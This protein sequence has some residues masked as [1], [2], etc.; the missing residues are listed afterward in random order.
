[1]TRVAQVNTTAAVLGMV[2]SAAPAL[3][4]LPSGGDTDCATIAYDQGAVTIHQH[5][6]HCVIDWQTFDIGDGFTV[7]FDQALPTWRTLNRVTGSELSLIAG[8]MVAPGTVYFVNPAGII[9]T[10]TAEINVGGIYAVAGSMTD[11]DFMDR[12]DLFTDLAGNVINEGSIFGA[13]VHMIGRRVVNDGTI[14]VDGVVTLLAGRDEVLIREIGDRIMVRIDGTDL[15]AELAVSTGNAIPTLTGPA[16]IENRGTIHAAGGRIVL[17]AGDLT[18]LAIRN[19]GKIDAGGGGSAQLAAPGGTVMHSGSG[20]TLTAADLT[21]TG[22]VIFIDSDIDTQAARFNDPVVLGGSVSIGG[23]E[24]GAASVVFASTVDSQAGESNVLIVSGDAHFVGDVG[25]ATTLSYLGVTGDAILGGDVT[26]ATGIVFEGDLRLD[27]AGSQAVDA[28]W[29]LRARGNVVK[30]GAGDLSL[31]GASLIDVDGDVTV[32]TDGGGLAMSGQMQLGGDVSAGGNVVF[33]GNPRS[34]SDAGFVGDTAFTGIGDQAV[35]AGG[36]VHSDG[37]MT[38][39][40]TGSLSILGTYG[41]GLG[42]DVAVTGDGDITLTGTVVAVNGDL[43]STGGRVVLNGLAWVSGSVEAGIDARFNG[44]AVVVGDVVA[45]GDDVVF[46]EGARIDGNV[47]AGGGV[48]FNDGA[49]LGG[50]VAALADDLTFRGDLT[51]SGV[52]NRQNQR[53]DAAADLTF[54]GDVTKITSGT[55]TLVGRRQI[56]FDGPTVTA[57][58]DIQLNPDGRATVPDVATMSAA[59]DL[60]ISSQAGS[61]VMGQNE[62]LTSLGELHLQAL[63]SLTVGDLNSVGDMHVTAQ[64][65]FLLTRSPGP[66]LDFTGSLD[67]DTGLDYVSTGRFF[68]SVTP[69]SI[70]GS[71]AAIFGSTFADADALGTLGGFTFE[72]QLDRGPDV[73][74]RGDT[75]LDLVAVSFSPANLAEALGGRPR[76]PVPLP[77]S[78]DIVL[79][80]EQAARLA[81]IGVNARPLRASEARGMTINDAFDGAGRPFESDQVAVNR[82]DRSAI[83]T[84]ATRFDALGERV[85]ALGSAWQAYRAVSAVPPMMTG[86]GDFGKYLDASPDRSEAFET[87]GVLQDVAHR[88]AISGLSARELSAAGDAILDRCIP[89]DA[90]REQFRAVIFPGN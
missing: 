11:G 7:N 1:M 88:L 54:A 45:H 8:T 77:V 68:F 23:S 67:Q 75:V 3:A 49:V 43:T 2:V 28:G 22:D 16:S 35:T 38:K 65:I 71:P 50:D 84:A 26:T 48:D 13:A 51:L 42:G 58:D 36:I 21:M 61:I 29:L 59:G 20:S 41:V 76:L 74:T 90:P 44:G 31:A 9:F 5:Q 63:E 57:I 4:Q 70:G 10:G 12:R 81:A 14:A 33:V 46:S 17:G 39:A 86:F 30:V 82:L 18:S 87:L 34:L 72:R 80:P 85:D 52:G 89:A 47:T 83:L 69:Q 62:K 24:N 6:P 55:L 25:S 56:R 40:G 15:A 27:R 60:A 79:S 37:S 64:E 66:V 53:L 73:F 78:R 19:S 32:A